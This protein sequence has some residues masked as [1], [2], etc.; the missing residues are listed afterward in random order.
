MHGT[1]NGV[2]LR[3]IT[4]LKIESTDTA[5]LTTFRVLERQ[6]RDLEAE[7]RVNAP[8]LLILADREIEGTVAFFESDG[9]GYRITIESPIHA[10]DGKMHSFIIRT[11]TSEYLAKVQIT[12]NY[13]EYEF[14]TESEHATRLNDFDSKLVLKR[15]RT[16]GETRARREEVE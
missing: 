6:L 4:S 14:T 15:L 16:L 2:R 10:F 3:R 11:S 7:L 8:A 1:F 9:N 13:L 12:S 5:I